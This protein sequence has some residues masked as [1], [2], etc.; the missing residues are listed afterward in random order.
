MVAVAL[1]ATWAGGVVFALLWLAAALAIAHEWNAMAGTEPS[2]TLLLLTGSGLVALAAGQLAGT[3]PVV[4][5]TIFGATVG[6]LAL[7]AAT[8][9]SRL[10]ST[11]GFAYAAI[12]ALVPAAVR[13]EPAL[14][15]PAIL[16]MFAVVWTTDIAAYFAGRRLG[17][18]KLWPSV[19]PKKTWSGFTGGLVGA[20]LAGVAVAVLA[21]R[22][23]AHQ[24][25]G[26]AAVALAAAVASIASQL[27]DLAES[28]MKRRFGAKDSGRLIPGHGGV[29][30]RLDG[31]VAVALLV[32]L[33]LAGTR[34]AR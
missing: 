27:G 34:L 29:M 25:A 5:L 23:G 15:L 24:S 19:S 20:I 1:L 32:G 22:N 17:G 30:D 4:L 10:W 21:A 8:A 2:R 31:F 16:W 26:L 7:A 14:G 13:D 9:R 28:A 3:G 33:A 11:A 12:V 6:S 18:P